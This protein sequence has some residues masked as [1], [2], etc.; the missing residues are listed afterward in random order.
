[1]YSLQLTLCQI[2][3]STTRH[4]LP[5]LALS[6]F[7]VAATLLPT[8]QAQEANDP[9]WRQFQH[10]LGMPAP[11]GV[12]ASHPLANSVVRPF[13]AIDLQDINPRKYLLGND[14]YQERALSADNS[15]GCFICHAGPLSGTDGRP[16]S[17]GVA[18]A[19]GNVNALTTFNAAFNFRQFWNGRAVTLADQALLPIVTAH[20]MAN[21]LE[22]VLATLQTDVGY[23]EEFTA[24]YPDGISSNNLADAIAHFERTSFAVTDTPFQ[25]HLQG[26]DAALSEQELRGWQRFQEIGC[27]SCHNGINLGGNSYQKLGALRPYFTVRREAGP[28]DAGLA[29]R[30]GRAQDLYVV[31]VPSLHNVAMTEPY[32]H[33]GSLDSLQSVTAEMARF[34]LGRELSEEDIGDIVVFM[35]ALNG[36]PAG[37]ELEREITQLARIQDAATAAA[38]QSPIVAPHRAAYRAAQNAVMPGLTQLQA[39][40]GRVESGEVAHFDFVQFQHLELIRHAR[41]LQHPPSDLADSNK[42]CLQDGAVQLLEDVM[43]LELPI[44]DYLQARAMLGVL[45]AHRRVPAPDSPGADELAAQSATHIDAARESLRAIADASIDEA[46]SLL[47]ECHW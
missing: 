32:L 8:L 29:E 20:E 25:R 22:K 31:K 42:Q 34:E 35:V 4:R 28:N 17:R 11:I 33:D 38:T 26:E 40:L 5:V 14:L 19:A 30:S 10:A 44:A 23:V 27:S 16:V 3:R 12:N 6:S 37:L 39:E 24:L 18:H 2:M 47:A 7:L 43:A 45:D 21:T 46:A 13:P 36:P 9:S 15:I 1:M 41:A